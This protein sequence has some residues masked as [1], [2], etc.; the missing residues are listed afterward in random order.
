MDYED[1]EVL[2]ELHDEMHSYEEERPTNNFSQTD[3]TTK[4]IIGL[5]A[6]LII[7]GVMLEKINLAT[8][9]IILGV[10]VFVFFFIKTNSVKPRTELSDTQCRMRIAEQLDFNR[11]NIIGDVRQIPLGKIL[12][13]MVG[14]KQFYEGKSFK[15]SYKVMIKN[16]SKR[17][18]FTYF[19]ECDIYSGDI[20]TFREAP[21]GVYG[22]ETKDIKYIPNPT[23][24][25]SKIRDKY[26][27]NKVNR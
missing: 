3:N 2:N 18:W 12:V 10:G 5:L 9:L 15:R 13:S 20:I 24:R 25:G 4:I 21:Q 22:D 7:I 6:G 14:R 11:E 23:D 1:N 16:N 26:F 17:I 27:G 8:G 19:V